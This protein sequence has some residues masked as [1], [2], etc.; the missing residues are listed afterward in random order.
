MKSLDL[1][2]EI[3]PYT[4]PNEIRK[5]PIKERYI[6]LF[7]FLDRYKDNENHILLSIILPVYNEERIIHS[8]LEN[9]PK[10]KNIEIIVVDDHSTDNS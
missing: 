3:K 7:E 10:N 2:R 1:K 5:K 8:V 6:E 9:L 4:I